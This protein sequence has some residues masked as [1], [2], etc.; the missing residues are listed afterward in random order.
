MIIHDSPSF[1]LT[2]KTTDHSAGRTVE[3]FQQFP[4]ALHP[5]D[6]RTLCLTLPPE[7]F[8]ALGTVFNSAAHAP[9]TPEADAS[10][11]PSHDAP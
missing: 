11:E 6:H 2:S 10:L 7:S 3:L 4:A 5:R 9:L 8:A 1:K